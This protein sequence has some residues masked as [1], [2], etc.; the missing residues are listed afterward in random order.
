MEASGENVRSRVWGL[1]ERGRERGRTGQRTPAH[2]GTRCARCART[3]SSFPSALP[4]RTKSFRLRA[5]PGQQQDKQGSSPPIP[6]AAAPAAFP[7]HPEGPRG[8]WWTEG[9][10]TIRAEPLFSLKVRSQPQQDVP[11]AG[12]APGSVPSQGWTGVSLPPQCPGD[13]RT[14][15]GQ[16]G[17]PRDGA[18]SEGRTRREPLPTPARARW[19]LPQSL[20]GSGGSGAP[21]LRRV[22]H[23]GQLWRGGRIGSSTRDNAAV[24]GQCRPPPETA[25]SRK[26]HPPAG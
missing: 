10:G 9:R 19:H 24:P 12:A 22:Q 23:P 17:H 26:R 11:R 20:P 14:P 6:A 18:N 5:Q 13:M 16:P 4:V 2:P 8:P 1:S 7:A 21:A 3:K 15:W 25:F